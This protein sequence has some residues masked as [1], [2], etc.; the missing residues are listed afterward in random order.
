M[1]LGFLRWIFFGFFLQVFGT[2][3]VGALILY[4]LF[5]GGE[6]IKKTVFGWW[7]KVVTT[8]VQVNIDKDGT[9]TQYKINEQK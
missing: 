8:T 9:T 3:I 2:L 5:G 4:F 7:N 6:G 1:I